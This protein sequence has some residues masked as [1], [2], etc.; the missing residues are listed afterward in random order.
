[1]GSGWQP[2]RR[3]AEL[4]QQAD[5]GSVAIEHLWLL[6]EQKQQGRAGGAG[7]DVSFVHNVAVG[8]AW[9]TQLL[10]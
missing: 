4:A 9:L 1:M 6:G 2:E 10:G 5:A 7:F 3:H 8:F